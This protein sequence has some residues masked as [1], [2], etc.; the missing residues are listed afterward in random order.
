[1][2]EGVEGDGEEGG[3]ECSGVRAKL[4]EMR[5]KIEYETYEQKNEY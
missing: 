2:Q 3:E 5:V 4:D 1:V